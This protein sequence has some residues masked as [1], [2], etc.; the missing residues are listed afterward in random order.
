MTR[1]A[2]DA[3]GNRIADGDKGAALRVLDHLFAV[4]AAIAGQFAVAFLFR[5]D[6]ALQHRVTD[7]SEQ[8]QQQNFNHEPTIYSLSG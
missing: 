4:P 8:N 1:L 3:G 5:I 6:Q 2:V 7:K